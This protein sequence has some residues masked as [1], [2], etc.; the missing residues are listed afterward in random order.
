MKYPPMCI[1]S[2]TVGP[3]QCN[4]S[5]EEGSDIIAHAFERGIGFVDTAQL[6]NTYEYI[7]LAIKKSGVNPVISTKSYAYDRLSAEKAFEEARKGL[8]RDY[9]DIFMLHEQESRLTLRGHREALEFYIEKKQQGLIRAVGVSTHNIC[10]VEAAAD[11]AEIDVIHPI[12]NFKGTG[13]NDGSAQDMEIAVERAFSNGKGI[14]TMKPLGG[15]SL[16][17]EYNVSIQYVLEKNY[18]HSVAIGMSSRAEVDMN[19][20]VFEGKE[21][22]KE[23]KNMVS[24]QNRQL[25]IESWCENCGACIERCR[26]DA[27]SAGNIKPVID[28]EKCVV[29]GYCCSVCPVFALKIY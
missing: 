16:I 3:L 23:T 13:I 17:N 8:D 7:R 1:G 27:L 26:Q 18:I 20:A 9:I 14:F 6:Y 11:M 22:D 4:L 15:G 5:H 10:V 19:I 28:K 21:P 25:H 29:C 24:L 12:F 2:L